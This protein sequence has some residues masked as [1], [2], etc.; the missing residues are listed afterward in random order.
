VVNGRQIL[1]LIAGAA[2]FAALP[3]VFGNYGLYLGS[4]LCVWIIFA[5]AYDLAFGR[6]GLLSFGHAMFFGIGA[7]APA[8]LAAKFGWG[9]W[10]GIASAIVLAGLFAVV[11]GNIALRVTGHAFVVITVIFSAIVE[12]LAFSQKWLTNGEDGISVNIDRVP[13]GFTSL[14]LHDSYS[15]YS[16]LI[17]FLLLTFLLLHWINSSTLGLAFRAVRENARRA[18][19][20][21]YPVHRYKLAA[22]SISGALSGLAGALFSLLNFHVSAE[23]FQI[24][25]SINPLTSVLVGGAGTMLGPVVGTAFIFLLSDYLRSLVVYADFAI[26][27]ILV[28]TVLFAP[29]GLVGL[30]ERYKAWRVR[31]RDAGPARAKPAAETRP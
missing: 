4:G 19:L 15:R 26:G 10:P 24:T 25:V 11:I 18:M 23:T 6:A 21:G 1:W 22:F 13:L 5:L 17:V 30:L 8:V 12:L 31:S 9:F 14:D 3:V 7:Y 29:S 2:L 16:L 20:L 27:V 28:L